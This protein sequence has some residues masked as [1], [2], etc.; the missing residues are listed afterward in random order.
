M[1]SDAVRERQPQ[2]LVLVIG[3]CHPDQAIEGYPGHVHSILSPR[4]VF[5]FQAYR[6]T[7]ISSPSCA[8]T[9]PS[10]V[11]L[12]TISEWGAQSPGDMCVR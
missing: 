11:S 6:P 1:V 4:R 3:L 5:Q 7:E 12:C 9:N 8:T 10:G 2:R